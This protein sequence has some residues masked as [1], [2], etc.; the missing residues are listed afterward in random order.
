MPARGLLV[1][2][3]FLTVSPQCQPRTPIHVVSL[4]YPY[5][6]RQARIQGDAMLIAHI[7]S[8]GSVSIPIRKSGHPMLLQAAEDNLKTW[9]FQ[10][11]ESQEMEITYHFKL[12]EQSSGPAQTECAFDLPDSVT[13]SS[14]APPVETIY[15]SPMGKPSPR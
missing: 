11:G 6:A 12:K 15:S 10:T 14:D 2:L 13:I 9:K 4:F 3:L 8:D 7:G 5:L 1:S